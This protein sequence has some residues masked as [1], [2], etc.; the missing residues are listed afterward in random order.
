MHLKATFLKSLFLGISI[1]DV[2]PESAWRF[3]P[4]EVSP[5]GF[6]Q[7]CPEFTVGP[8]VEKKEPTIVDGIKADLPKRR[9]SRAG[10]AT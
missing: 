7:S 5:A 10:R 3:L 6:S 1:P 8:K 9:G 4:E 2:L